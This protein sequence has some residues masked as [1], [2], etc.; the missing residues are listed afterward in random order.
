MPNVPPGAPFDEQGG[1]LRGVLDLAAGRYPGFLFGLPVGTLLP[2]FHFHQTTAAVLEPAFRYLAENG[3]RT[4]LSDDAARLVREG[5]HPGA[6]TVMLAFD[7]AF[8]SL[9]LVVGPLLEK[10]DLRA[11]TY[12]IPAR[13]VDAPEVRSTGTDGPVDAAA[14]DRADNPFVTW[15]ELRAL[16]DSGRVDVQSHTWSHSMIFS[17]QT[18]TGVVDEAFGREPSI[19]HPRVNA[20]TQLEFL[21]PSRLGHPMFARRSRMSDGRRFWPD[22]DA[23]ARIERVVEA[24]GGAA[25]FRHAG[26]RRELAPLL[27]GTFPGRWES[28]AEQ[29]HEIESELS[30]SRDE[31]EARLKKPVRHVC[32]PWGITG[33]TT[34]AALERLGFASAYANRLSGR[35]AVAAGDDPFFLKRLHSRHIFALPGR[36]RRIF[37]TLAG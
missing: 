34:R 7:D 22:A 5:R 15:P 33:A 36:H 18:V 23:S 32:L 24:G 26:W 13:L 21:Q 8:A 14:A 3:Y 2:V 10:Y 28:V 35:L 17:G 11:V 19:I 9:W 27:E 25:F 37:T 30:Q 29:R 6:R 4:V 20:G 1:R 16:S 12:A 31:L